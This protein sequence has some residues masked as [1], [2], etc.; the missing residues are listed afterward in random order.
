[1]VYDYNQ[2]N[3]TDITWENILSGIN[4]YTDYQANENHLSPSRIKGSR[5]ERYVMNSEKGKKRFT[6]L[7]SYTYTNYKED[8]E[9]ERLKS[10]LKRTK[11]LPVQ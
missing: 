10:V 6:T 1:M 11:I 7:G 5:S 8:F 2:Y 9:E 4:P 3:L